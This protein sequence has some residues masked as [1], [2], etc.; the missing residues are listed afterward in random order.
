MFQP[1]RRKL[2]IFGFQCKSVCALSRNPYLL[3]HKENSKPSDNN[4]LNFLLHSY[5]QICSHFCPS[6]L[7]SL[8]SFLHSFFLP[9]F[10]SQCSVSH[11]CVQW[12]DQGCVSHTLLTL[13][14]S[15]FISPQPFI[16]YL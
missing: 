16:L 5:R 8:P 6:F 11:L 4:S 15:G 13:Y 14:S 12:T 10:I 7:S 2:I 9:S 1:L 3:P